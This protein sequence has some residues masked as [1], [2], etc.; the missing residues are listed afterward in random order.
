MS[1]DAFVVVLTSIMT[2][3]PL[4]HRKRVLCL[5]YFLFFIPLSAIFYFV[6]VYCE[7]ELL[8]SIKKLNQSEVEHHHDD[9]VML[10][11]IQ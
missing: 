7:R 5:D 2:V 11:I 10:T 6:V 4:Y 8:S 1:D 3:A 9:V